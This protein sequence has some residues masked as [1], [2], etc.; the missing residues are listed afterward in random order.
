MS[1]G[2]VGGVVVAAALVLV[3]LGVRA[4]AGSRPALALSEACAQAGGCCIELQSVCISNGQIMPNMRP[5]EGRTCT[6]PK[7]G[8]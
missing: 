1:R 4:H 7:P 5:S 3:P 8:T 6:K 2:V